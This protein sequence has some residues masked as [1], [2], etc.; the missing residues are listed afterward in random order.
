MMMKI[1]VNHF[2]KY[3]DY[4]SVGCRTA[5]R[6]WRDGVRTQLSAIFNWVCSVGRSRSSTRLVQEV[7]QQLKE[8]V[9]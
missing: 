2:Q 7:Q 4:A 3:F 8:T 1:L 9:S 5:M 6:G